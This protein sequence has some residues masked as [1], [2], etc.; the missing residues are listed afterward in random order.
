MGDSRPPPASRP[1][2]PHAPAAKPATTPAP[3]GGAGRGHDALL[4]MAASLAAP[5]QGV[6]VGAPDAPAEA[7]A[8]A[9]AAR[10]MA[11]GAAAGPVDARPLAF[12][13]NRPARALGAG[14]GEPLAAAERAFF[15]PRLGRGLADARLHRGPAA[16]RATARVG[17]RAFALGPDVFLGADADPA[18]HEG[19]RIL[20]H[21]LAHVAQDGGGEAVL[22]RV[23]LAEFRASLEA[24]SADHRK[25]ISELFTHPKF[26]PL[27]TFLDNCPA[28]TLDYFVGHVTELVGGVPVELFGGF[29]PGSPTSQLSVN[30]FRA[31]HAANPLE[32]VDTIV[33]EVL[34]GIVSLAPTCASGANPNPLTG[35]GIID[36]QADPQL[37][38]YFGAGF[39]DMDRASVTAA[40]AAGIRTTGGEDVLTYFIRQY[41]PS[42]SRPKTHFVDLNRPGN[43][44]VTSI[45][46]DIHARFPTI[47]KET[48]SFDNV[49][50]SKAEAL[51]PTRPWLNS[52]QFDFSKRLFKDQV[53]VKRSVE[54]ATYTD[55]EYTISAIQ[56]VEFADR[57]FFDDNAHGGWG[58]IG[59]V[60]ECVKTSRFTGKTL[61]ATVTGHSGAKPGGGTAYRIVQHS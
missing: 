52:T 38:P 3:A 11:P 57:K 47:G 10:V 4:R 17:A 16:E 8:D 25:V 5:R 9:T 29:D 46:T 26:I 59:G 50:L 43:E 58:P 30:P 35:T 31:E 20:A 19:R 40:S 15:E 14:E 42:A 45:I 60:W 48:V 18:S 1:A 39:S 13:R 23:T 51:I 22:R 41:G 53:A 27:I 37:T 21:E 28:G 36:A 34:H 44:L 33:H 6:R 49:E 54:P 61:K 55:R 2:A 12:A 56:A 32:M 7:A 24:T